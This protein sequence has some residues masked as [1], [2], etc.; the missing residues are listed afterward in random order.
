MFAPT[1]VWRRWHRKINVNQR[2]Y[3]VTSA[4][5]ASAV[6]SLVMARGHKIDDVPEFPLVLS[7]NLNKIKTTKA[8]E[9][10]LKNVGAFADVEK[11]ANSKKIRTGTGKAR[12]RRYVQRKGPLVVY[13]SSEGLDK[14]FRNLPG[15]DLCH[16]DNMNLL[17]L[18]P[19]GHIGRFIIWTKG[20]FERLDALFGTYDSPSQLKSGF[21]LPHSMMSNA[22]LAR[23][24]NS[25]EIQSI[26][27]APVT[28]V[29]S[30][31]KKRNPLTHSDVMDGLNPYAAE[32]RA[33]ETKNNAGTDKKKKRKLAN[34]RSK[35]FSKQ[36]RA[37]Y[38]AASV[39]GD[40]A[41]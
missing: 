38:A 39:E 36:K 40:I 8:A 17:D 27:K 21:M 1:K 4:L 16:V 37:F 20:A 26:V 35:K 3:A 41:F 18:A 32:I 14:A 29:N 24:I 11:S 13:E 22:D 33:K 6:P 30:I 2:R 12:N 9:S 25:D 10:S 31:P 7:D 19:G 5:A 23:I 28:A 15:V 34:E